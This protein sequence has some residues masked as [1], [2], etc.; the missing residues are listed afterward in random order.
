MSIIEKKVWPEFFGL[1]LSGKK[2]FEL[3]LADFECNPG[4]V[5][6][7]REYDPGTKKYT[8]R[9]I[10]KTVVYVMETKGQRFWDEKDVKKHGFQVIG[11]E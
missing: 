4:D 9:S 10:E 11:F 7:L 2:S 3:R 1:I 5:L 8:G 6:M